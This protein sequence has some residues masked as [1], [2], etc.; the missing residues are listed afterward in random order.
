MSNQHHTILIIGGG[1]AGVSVANNLR[2][3]NTTIDVALVE[4]SEVH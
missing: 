2:R 1:A 3:I 4:P